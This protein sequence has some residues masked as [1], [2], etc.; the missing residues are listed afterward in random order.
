MSRCACTQKEAELATVRADTTRTSEQLASVNTR[1]QDLMSLFGMDVATSN[2]IM[3]QPRVQAR[4]RR[5]QQPIY[6][7]PQATDG[8]AAG[9]DAGMEMEAERG[10]DGGDAAY[11]YQPAYPAA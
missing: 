11:N 4:A 3:Q 7:S 5:V 10:N 6:G 2:T 9:M 8:T 1:F